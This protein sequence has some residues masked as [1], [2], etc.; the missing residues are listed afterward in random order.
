M[1]SHLYV[2]IC[3]SVLIGRKLNRRQRVCVRNFLIYIARKQEIVKQSKPKRCGERD[4]QREETQK[5]FAREI[6]FTFPVLF[7]IHPR[8]I[9]DHLKSTHGT[10]L[11]RFSQYIARKEISVVDSRIPCLVPSSS[12]A[13]FTLAAPSSFHF[14]TC[15]NPDVADRVFIPG[16]PLPSPRWQEDLQVATLGSFTSP[17]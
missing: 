7:F 6:H 8:E 11:L 16:F 13:P 12:S 5:G 14:S 17:R 9:Q 1:Q 4:D 15:N 2:Q 3:M 10:F